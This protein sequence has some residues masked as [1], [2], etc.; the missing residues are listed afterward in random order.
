[1]AKQIT[2]QIQIYGEMAPG[3]LDQIA[4]DMSIQIQGKLPC[5]ILGYG[6][7]D[8]PSPF[9]PSFSVT[10]RPGVVDATVEQSAPIQMLNTG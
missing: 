2:V 5:R 7:T 1:M 8:V 10:G 9:A 4:Y 3:D 6:V